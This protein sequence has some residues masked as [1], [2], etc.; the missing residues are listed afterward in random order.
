MDYVIILYHNT[1][2]ARNMVK[3]AMTRDIYLIYSFI[4]KVTQAIIN[5]SN[6]NDWN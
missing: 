6:Y 5:Q 1:S 4:N 2:F 3:F